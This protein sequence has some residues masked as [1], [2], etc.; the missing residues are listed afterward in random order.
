[1]FLIF[2]MTTFSPSQMKFAS[3]CPVGTT[4]KVKIEF[5]EHRKITECNFACV[6]L[7]NEEVIYMFGSA[8]LRIGSSKSRV[9]T[10]PETPGQ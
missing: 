2:L 10:V 3:P 1:M 4:V 5:V 9:F 8:K 7:T 6:D